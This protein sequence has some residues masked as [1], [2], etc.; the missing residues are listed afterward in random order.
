[1]A[2]T[3]DESD[4]IR[5]RQDRIEHALTEIADVLF[6]GVIPGTLVPGGL[7]SHGLTRL[8]NERPNLAAIVAQHAGT[9]NVQPPDYR[10]RQAAGV[11]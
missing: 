5:R 10:G 7:A 9:G 4:D 6:P 8:Q 11:A 1:M 2:N 3:T